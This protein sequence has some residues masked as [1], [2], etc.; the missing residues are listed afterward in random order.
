[1]SFSKKKK[2]KMAVFYVSVNIVS[3][4]RDERTDVGNIPRHVNCVLSIVWEVYSIIYSPQM[5]T[6]AEDRSRAYA[7][8]PD[9]I[10][11]Y[12]FL[13]CRGTGPIFV[14]KQFLTINT[15]VSSLKLSQLMMSLVPYYPKINISRVKINFQERVLHLVQLHSWKWSDGRCKYEQKPEGPGPNQAKNSI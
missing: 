12:L 2:Q 10:L 3:R 15:H 5:D 11:N 14:W 9:F 6:N 7:T 13:S 1:M 4:K 8:G